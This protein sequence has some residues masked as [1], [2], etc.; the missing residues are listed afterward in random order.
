MIKKLLFLL[1]ICVSFISASAQKTITF[2]VDDQYHI[3][4]LSFERAEALP[5]ENNQVTVTVTSNT[6]NLIYINTVSGYQ[7]KSVTSTTT[8]VP[9]TMSQYDTSCEVDL[10]TVP[11]G[12]V[13]NIATM[14]SDQYFF[15]FKGEDGLKVVSSAAP[16]D[17]VACVGG[18]YMVEVGRVNSTISISVMEENLNDISIVKVEVT[19]ED[20]E[21]FMPNASGVVTIPTSDFYDGTPKNVEFEIVTAAVNINE[22]STV[23]VT[24]N[25][26][27]NASQLEF[28]KINTNGASTVTFNSIP[29]TKSVRFDSE[30]TSFFIGLIGG[31]LYGIS[32]D[33]QDV[34]KSEC[35]AQSTFDE[36]LGYLLTPGSAYYP[37]DGGNI[38][39]Y[40]TEPVVY[41]TVNFTFTNPS[42]SAFVTSVTVGSDELA[43][44]VW[45]GGTFSVQKNKTLSLTFNTVDYK[46]NSMTVNGSAISGNTYSGT[47]STDLD[48][49]FNV[50]VAD[51]NKVTV[52]SEGWQHL[53][54]TDANGTN[55]TLS[56]AKTELAVIPSVKALIIKATEGYFIP[57][58]GISVSSTK[59]NAGD[60]VPVANGTTI[61]VDVEEQVFTFNCTADVLEFTGAQSNPTVT[62]TAESGSTPAH[63]T[64]SSLPASLYGTIKQAFLAEYAIDYVQYGDEQIASYD[65]KS[66]TISTMQINGNAIFTVVF[67]G[68]VPARN[69][70]IDVNNSEFVASVSNDKTTITEFP[71][72]YDLNNGYNLTVTAAEGCVINSVSCDGTALYDGD[73]AAKVNIDLTNVKEGSTVM[74]EASSTAGITVYLTIDNIEAVEDSYYATSPIEPFLFDDKGVATLT[75]TAEQSEV[76]VT[77]TV[78]IE[79]VTTEG[80][81]TITFS[82]L[83]ATIVTIDLSKCVDGQ[84]VAITTAEAG[85]GS[86][87]SDGIEANE[88]YDLKGIRISSDDLHRGIYIRGGKKIFVK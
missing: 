70:T 24:V 25:S 76:T 2:K 35:T 69:V 43:E 21:P 16:Y 71:G 17:Y 32:V 84:T 42:T 60:A 82:T 23:S 40:I 80:E 67:K 26:G 20:H 75:V 10:S 19:S 38:T 61:S 12:T 88:V 57:K 45:S 72:L 34:P 74:I 66:F 56:S 9:V 83:P 62:Y 1:A 28:Y 50:A 39:I 58:D 52:S 8:N 77:T 79:T 41:Q 87:V 11:S 18:T 31:E 86:I 64:V 13:I 22:N 53:T 49:V 37:K 63:Y 46:V 29:S 3:A 54:V 48:F 65:G 78:D 47:V 68:E 73:A 85:I 33:G 7:F 27:Q 81:G 51:P 14:A 44:S 4:S 55:Y 30:Q 59:Y 5:F 6:G 15:T 36:K